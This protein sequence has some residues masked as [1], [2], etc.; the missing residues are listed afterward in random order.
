MSLAYTRGKTSFI[1]DFYV[2]QT[3]NL[4][5]RMS[6]RGPNGYFHL[7]DDIDTWEQVLSYWLK[8]IVE[9]RNRKESGILQE[10][11]RKSF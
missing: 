3:G 7:A 9:L 5:G 2:G 6:V 8:E 1:M 11:D 10:G 4:Y